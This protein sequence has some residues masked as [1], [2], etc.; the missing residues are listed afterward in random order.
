MDRAT[1]EK[2]VSII[3]RASDLSIATNRPDGYPQNT[4]VSYVNDGLAIYFGTSDKA[5]KAQN[6]AQDDKISLTINLPYSNWEHIRG[7]SL[8]GRACRI[9]DAEEFQ[10]VGELMY[11]KFPQ[12]V[13]YAPD[14]ATLGEL[15]LFR[16]DPEVISVL[17]Y[18]K[19]FG[20]ADLFRL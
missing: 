3:D 4:T 19:G 1:K 18:S 13:A 7:I 9:V 2:I 14:A 20:H 16:I 12:I 5:Q 8:G 17:D 11:D 15:L 10:K 6:I